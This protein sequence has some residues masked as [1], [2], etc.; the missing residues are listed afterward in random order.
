MLKL[1]WN[2]GAATFVEDAGVYA[3]YLLFLC[4]YLRKIP[5][6]HNSQTCIN[7]LKLSVDKLKFN[8]YKNFL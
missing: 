3:S 1:L 4:I 7:I 2:H 8:W 6:R 5:L